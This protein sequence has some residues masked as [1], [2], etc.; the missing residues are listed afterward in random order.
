M[1]SGKLIKLVLTVVSMSK[2]QLLVVST[3]DLNKFGSFLRVE[4]FD[5]FDNMQQGIIPTYTIL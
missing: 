1:A 4:Y 3:K 2:N 5:I